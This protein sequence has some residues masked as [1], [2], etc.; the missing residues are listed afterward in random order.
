MILEC[1]PDYDKNTVS[2]SVDENV[3][4]ALTMSGGADTAL[5][6]YLVSLELLETNRRPEEYIKWIF[7]FP[8]RDGAEIYPDDIINW[9]NKKLGIK[10]PSK[11]IV[12]L[13][14]LHSTYHGKQV[15]QSVLYA[16][17]KY[18]PDR[19][20]M[21]DQQVAPDSA[22][23]S[24]IRPHRSSTLEGPLPGR[25]LFPFNHL[26]KYHNID[27][28][29]KLGIEELLALTHSCTQKPAGRCNKCYHCLERKCS[30]DV[31]GLTDPGHI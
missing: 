16:L 27:I 28:F 18:S 30:F 19:L 25:V 13:P 5:L 2:I 4:V 26:Y 20:Y 9:I 10:L 7:T 31:L 22:N 6:A 21:G 1:G 29:F 15:W 24:E 8:K 12:K 11:T 17:T 14:N 3:S 23:I